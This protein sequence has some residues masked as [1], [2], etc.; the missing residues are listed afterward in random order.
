MEPLLKITSIPIDIEVKI[1]RA[2]MEPI[3]NELPKVRISRDKGEFNIDAEPVSIQ[4]DNTKMYNSIGLKKPLTRGL[5]YGDKGLSVCYQGV[6]KIVDNA[7]AVSDG[8]TNAS[9]IAKNEMM[10]DA[11]SALDHVT[12][13]IPEDG[14]DISWKDGRLSINYTADKLNIDFDI[15]KTRFKFTPGS[16][17]LIVNQLPRVEIEYT[18]DPIYF[19]ASAN[20]NYQ[21]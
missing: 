12:A 21:G 10:S 16:V 3:D 8:K 9:E 14:P 7:V 15:H 13:F 1:N 18:G 19:P 17:E 6:A 11:L 20:P 5:E 2:T 4:I